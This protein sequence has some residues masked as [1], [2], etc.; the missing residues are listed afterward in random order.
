MGHPDST[1]SI[2]ID[3]TYN[4]TKNKNNE[5]NELF[6]IINRNKLKYVIR[7]KENH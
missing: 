2:P 3:I 6:D 5:V 1:N 7:I 4:G